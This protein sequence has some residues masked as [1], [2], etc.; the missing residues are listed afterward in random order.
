MRVQPD[1]NTRARTEHRLRATVFVFEQGRN[2]GLRGG[3]P[4]PSAVGLASPSRPFFSTEVTPLAMEAKPQRSLQTL[5]GKPRLTA[6]AGGKPQVQLL[7]E[8]PK[9][10][11]VV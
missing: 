10:A 9:V 3:L 7:P 5:A 2:T 1:D 4:Q 6:L 8:T 11:I